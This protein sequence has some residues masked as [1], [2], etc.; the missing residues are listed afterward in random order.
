M[1]TKDMLDYIKMS[2]ASGKTDEQITASLLPGGWQLQDIQ[3]ALKTVDVAQANEAA[4]R[5]IKGLNMN[6][7]LRRNLIGVIIVVVAIFM[8]AGK[9]FHNV[10]NSIQIN[11]TDVQIEHGDMR[12]FAQAMPES[13]YTFVI[14]NGSNI[15]YSDGLFSVWT[16]EQADA[17]KARYGDFT[18]CNSPGSQAGMNSLSNIMVFAVDDSVRVKIKDLIRVSKN[19]PIVELRACQLNIERMV[20]NNNMR[21][22]WAG[23][24]LFYL[25]KDVSILKEN[26]NK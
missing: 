2:R 26:Y 17:L 11:G 24:E 12:I 14:N 25:I 3:E 13:S 16:M 7:G 21:I 9:L 18:H 6:W 22:M 19:E 23:E 1:V 5:N 8:A 10:H 20:K 15:G 4:S